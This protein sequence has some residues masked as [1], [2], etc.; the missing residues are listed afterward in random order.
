MGN[1]KNHSRR[2]KRKV[3][4]NQSVGQKKLKLNNERDNCC[5]RLRKL[6][7]SFEDV[8]LLDEESN[9]Y[10]ININFE[11]LK[12]FSCRFIACSECLSRNIEFGDDLSCRMGYAH[13][14]CIVCR[15]CSYKESTYTS[16]QS[17][18]ISKSQGRRKFDINIRTVVAFRGIGK[19]LEG[20]T[21]CYTLFEYV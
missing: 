18:K 6:E 20:D 19:G 4:G 10:Y 17:Q 13:K 8:P 15:D 5:L 9:D 14:I 3:H 11:I 1:Q 7:K 21:K 2:R 16:K 12:Q